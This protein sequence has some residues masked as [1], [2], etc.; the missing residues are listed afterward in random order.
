[1]GEAEGVSTLKILI[2]LEFVIVCHWNFWKNGPID[3][4]G[5]ISAQKISLGQFLGLF[6]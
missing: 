3:V 1:M 4:S 5:S 6:F 2:L